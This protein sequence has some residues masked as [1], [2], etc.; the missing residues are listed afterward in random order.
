MAFNSNADPQEET[1]DEPEINSVHVKGYTESISDLFKFRFAQTPTF[2]KPTKAASD[3]MRAYHNE[4][5][6]LAKGDLVDIQQFP[7]RWRENA[8]KLALCIHAMDDDPKD[9]LSV[10]TAEKAVRIGQWFTDQFLALMSG[11]R[12]DKLEDDGLW[13]LNYVNKAG[14]VYKPGQ[15]RSLAVRDIA[16]NRNMSSED[17]R[18]IV[19]TNLRRLRIE[20]VAP[21]KGGKT[22]ERVF[23]C[24]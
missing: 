6:R 1:G 24:Q 11:G 3:L 5:V 4:C 8:W 12:E 19:S 21:P 7:L 15:P 22:S 23:V 2:T 17:V 9:E 13:L 20:S 14:V 16:R 10:R 18:K